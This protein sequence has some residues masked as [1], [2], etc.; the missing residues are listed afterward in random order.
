LAKSRTERLTRRKL[1]E[2]NSI[3]IRRKI[4]GRGHPEGINNPK[5]YAIPCLRIINVS[6]VTKIDNATQKV[7]IKLLVP[8]SEYGSIPIKLLM[9]TKLKILDTLTNNSPLPSTSFPRLA[10]KRGATTSSTKSDS[11]SSNKKSS[12]SSSS[13]P[14]KRKNAKKKDT[15]FSSK[16]KIK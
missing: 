5:K 2:I 12:S 4:K 3:G 8:V 11:S 6:K 15:K 1:Y 10:I 16:D 7:N 9:K 13:D 14:P